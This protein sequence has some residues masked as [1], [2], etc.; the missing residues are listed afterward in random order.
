MATLY[1]AQFEV[2]HHFLIFIVKAPLAGVVLSATLP[3]QQPR[4]LFFQQH[5]NYLTLPYLY[6]LTLLTLLT[7][8]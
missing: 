8:P 2:Y 5:T 3:Q 6:L 7:L 4:H 1:L